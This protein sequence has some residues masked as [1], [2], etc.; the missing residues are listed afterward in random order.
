MTQPNSKKWLRLTLLLT[1][2]I[3]LIIQIPLLLEPEYIDEDLRFF[4]WLHR[5]ANPAL[6]EEDSLLGY[7]FAE[8]DLG[9]TTL[10]FNKV[11]LLYGTLYAVVSP[12]FSPFVFSKILIF[13]LAFVSSYYLFRITEHL[14]SPFTAFLLSIIFTLIV[15]V[16]Y[17]S[18]ALSSG[19]PRVFTLPL[20]LAMLH[21]MSINN[22]YGM[23]AVL[24]LGL[25]YPPI[26]LTILIAY[27]LKYIF[28]SYQRRQL[29]LTGKQ[30]TMFIVA[31]LLSVLLLL[32]AI[33]TG[34][35]TVPV[36][37]KELQDLTVFSSPLFGE[38]GRYSLL[39]PYPL[40]ANGGLLD[41]GL[42]GLYSLVFVFALLPIF[43]ILRRQFKNL[44][45]PFWYLVL[46]SLIGFVV[47]WLAILF[48][49]SAT[50]HMPSR[51]IRGTIFLIG[52]I[53]FVVNGPLAIQVSSK[54]LS[55]NRNMLGTI[56][57]L[58]GIVGSGMIYFSDIS[59]VL[60]GIIGLQVI[61]AAILVFVARKHTRQV[62]QQDDIYLT[63][64]RSKTPSKKTHLHI[65]SS[66][67][68]CV[69]VIPLIIYVQG[70]NNF[71][72][73]QKDTAELIDF[74]KTIPPNS[75]IAGYP[76]LLDDIPLYAQRAILFSCETESRDMD[77]MMAALDTYYAETEAEVLEFCRKYNIDY[78]V[79]NHTTFTDA[80][81]NQEIILFEP[82]NSFLKQQLARKQSFVI[83]QVPDDRKTF[84][85]SSYFVFPCTPDALR[86]AQ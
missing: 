42:V 71:Y 47:S 81:Q 27:S 55:E 82:L 25:I 37:S 77:M 54:Y 73:P 1:I 33:F 58:T 80:F 56:L 65:L 5:F 13:P 29:A 68:S 53:L 12:F 40:T 67:V 69:L 74:V 18:I 49:P 36:N 7:Q 43:L 19:L 78:M 8:V 41:R 60:K 31:F 38:N 17:S 51:Y 3:V 76:C 85:N 84:R 83:E 48:T 61:I 22:H 62:I 63:L 44:P 57:L 64:D 34:L 45:A 2:V 14:V 24:L 23:V 30:L 66:L 20:L 72:R 11:S 32:P 4:Y 10:L 16:P 21:Y 39:S 46:A 70:P 35:N 50:F 52:I 9:F 86:P 6:F 15:G 26:F 59:N 75:L 79:A 28:E